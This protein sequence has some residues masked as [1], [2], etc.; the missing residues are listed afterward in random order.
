MFDF[1]GKKIVKNKN[2]EYVELADK[3]MKK[4][5]LDYGHLSGE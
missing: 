1:Y 5:N 4:A 3:N 2:G